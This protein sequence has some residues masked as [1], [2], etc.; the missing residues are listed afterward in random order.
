LIGAAAP[1]GLIRRFHS[2][3][4]LKLLLFV[5]IFSLATVPPVDPDLWWHLANGRLLSTLHWWPQ[6][7]LYSFSA[8]G[9]PWVMHEWLADLLM[10]GVYQLGGL[11]L[12]VVIFAGVVTGG[13]ACLFLILRWSGLHPTAAVLLTLIGALAG[14][15]A[16]G[17]R[18]QLLNLLFSGLLICGLLLYR[19]GRLAPWWLVPFIWVWA[20]LHSGFVVGLII[21]FLFLLGGAIDGTFRQADL[22][23]RR[24]TQLGIAL[25][26]ATAVSLIN[27]YG[28]DTL[29][30]PLGT[31]TSALIQNNIQE[32]ASPDFHSLPGYLLE[33]I[34]FLILLGLATGKVKARTSDW[35]WAL[36][37]LY[38]ALSSQ[39]HVP[40]FALAAAP[41]MARCAQALI[42]RA[43]SVNLLEGQ[44]QPAGRAAFRWSPP[45]P[46]GGSAVVG[47]VNLALLL[48]VGV[49]M[50]AYR[51]LPNIRPEGQAAAISSSF[52]VKATD[53]LLNQGHPLRVFNYYDTGGYLV[54]RLYPSGGRVFIDGRV[55][56]YGAAVFR[57][58]LAVNYVSSG[59]RDVIARRA[60]DA[61]LL[62]TGHPVVSLLESDPGWRVLEKDKAYTLFLAG[63]SQ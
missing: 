33:A 55:E 29:L 58:Y 4:L 45:R 37:L 63:P 42:D 39:R 20:N 31:L 28:L 51:A 32:W 38:L 43:G 7:D 47:V 1:A 35:L 23:R 18:P 49:G 21:T 19:K 46:S 34:L 25:L 10:Y 54:W 12:L 9:H 61:V 16:W 52:P 17:A 3:L 53:A 57:D 11:P 24:L 22:P 2:G 30:F 59:W 5:S 36:A 50:V 26:L 41:L 14:S 62:P 8:A 6:T 60:P 56:V 48:V 40:L 44:G 15:T 27:P 13:A